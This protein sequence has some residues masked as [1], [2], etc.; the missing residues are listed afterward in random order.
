VASL[1]RGS[2]DASSLFS[3]GTDAGV[4]DPQFSIS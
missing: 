4:A 2:V 1:D 3:S